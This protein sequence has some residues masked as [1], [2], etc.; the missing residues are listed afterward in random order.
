M[1]KDATKGAE[2]A[3]SQLAHLLQ[4]AE[5]GRTTIITRRGRPVAALVPL[6]TYR[7]AGG[8]QR[9]LIKLEGSG[10]GLWGKDSRRTIKKLR[11]EWNP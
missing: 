9:P 11:E 1:A 10:S 8:R 4:D 5:G 6:E 3:R 7:G 2:E